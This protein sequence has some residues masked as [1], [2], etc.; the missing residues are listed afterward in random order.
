MYATSSNKLRHEPL[1]LQ[2]QQTPSRTAVALIDGDS[3]ECISEGLG[4]TP[5]GRP[6]RKSL[7]Y[8]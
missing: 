2:L 8:P 1:Q 7:G 6:R 5:E 3:M 4:V